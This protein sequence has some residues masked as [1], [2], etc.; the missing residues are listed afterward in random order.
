VKIR[1][2]LAI[3]VLGF[4]IACVARLWIGTLRFRY[5]PLGLN[6]DPRRRGLPGRYI[7]TLWHEN[8]MLPICSHARRDIWA[9]VSRHADGEVLAEACRRIG[10]GVVSGSTTRGGVEAVR[11]MLRKGRS[12]HLAGT[13]DGPRGPRR[14][15]Q[16]GFVYL[17]A[18]TGL[19]IVPIGFA[20]RGAWRLKSW[21]RFVLPHPWTAAVA[22]T[23]EPIHVPEDVSRDRLEDYRRRVEDALAEAT[24]A[25]ERRLAGRP[26]QPMSEPP[27]RASA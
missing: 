25:A 14:V 23:T 12:A 8:L 4:V 1:H 7:Y 9:L 13:P 19:P 5:R 21:D 6:V 11:Q 2:P 26:S 24:A 15:V 20:F 16:P 3:K 18:K 27:L 17:A 10:F 22:V